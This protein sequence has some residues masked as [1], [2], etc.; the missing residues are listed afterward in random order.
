MAERGEG[1]AEAER[2]GSAVFIPLP[3]SFASLPNELFDV[4]ADA[5]SGSPGEVTQGSVLPS[6]DTDRAGSQPRASLP[7][8]SPGAPCG[9]PRTP[10][11]CDPQH[12]RSA[13]GREPAVS[14]GHT[15]GWEAGLANRFRREGLRAA[16]PF[17]LGSRHI[18]ALLIFLNG[19]G[20]ALTD[21]PA[22]YT[23]PPPHGNGA[24]TGV[25]GT[26]HRGPEGSPV[27]PGASDGRPHAQT[28]LPEPP[29]ARCVQ[30]EARLPQAR[31]GRTALLR[32]PRAASS[33]RRPP[34]CPGTER[35]GAGRERAGP[36]SCGAAAPC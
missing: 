10:P 4:S 26:G 15:P 25:P 22:G 13:T 29:R 16:L 14:W 18:R 34:G 19:V 8:A 20:A 28:T 7:L 35:R 30:G 32:V 31:R 21:R 12:S 33:E 27:P 36:G 9:F 3:G 6:P 17:H 24:G 5:A 2:G 11:T 23:Q 1:R